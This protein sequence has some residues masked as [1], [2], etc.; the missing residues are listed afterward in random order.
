M[1]QQIF[2]ENDRAS[3]LV[4]PQKESFESVTLYQPK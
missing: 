3:N 4:E 1:N 2:N